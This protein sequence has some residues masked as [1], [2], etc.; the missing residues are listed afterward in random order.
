MIAQLPP[1][2]AV[3]PTLGWSVVGAVVAAVV[4]GGLTRPALVAC[5]VPVRRW[6]VVMTLIGLLL[7]AALAFAMDEL[8]CQQTPA[9]SPSQTWQDGRIVYHAVCLGLLL[10]ITATDLASLYIPNFVVNLG[11]VIAIIAAVFSGELQMAH[12]WVDWNEEIPDI[13]GPYIPEWIKHH[14]HLH[15]LAWSAVGALVGGGLT[16][17]VRNVAE[18]ALGRPAMGAGDVTLMAMIGAFLGWQAAVVAFFLAPMLALVLGPLARRVSRESAVPYGPFLATGAIIVMFAWRWIWMF[19]IDISTTGAGGVDDRATAFAVRRFFGD[20][21]LL[22]G[23]SVIAIGGTAGLMSL[24]RLFWT[25]PIE[26]EASEPDPLTL[27]QASEV[28]PVTDT[29]PESVPEGLPPGTPEAESE[30]Q[31]G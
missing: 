28:V 24:M 1:L 2:I 25:L 17:V 27:R 7:G 4:C 23:L 8:R 26:R 12:L 29:L 5:E 15:G 11:L 6:P 9:V 10:V 13:R 14:Q 18:F 22:A 21:V 31:D 3:S 30:A 19:E 16:A 20:A